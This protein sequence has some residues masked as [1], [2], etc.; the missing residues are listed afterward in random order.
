[1]QQTN[2]QN[3]QSVGAKMLEMMQLSSKGKHN[4]VIRNFNFKLNQF[5]EI[6]KIIQPIEEEEEEPKQ[7][8]T[9]KRRQWGEGGKRPSIGG[10]RAKRSQSRGSVE[11]KPVKRGV[12]IN[13]N[14]LKASS[15][16][17]IL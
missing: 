12:R 8:Q 16:D 4:K 3:R 17:P 11:R 1:M 5:D 9:G 7:K 15:E 14:P 10:S 6:D 13:R 2:E